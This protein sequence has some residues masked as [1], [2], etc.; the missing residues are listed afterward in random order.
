MT[1]IK[2]QRSTQGL[3]N[4][5]SVV[6]LQRQKSNKISF[7]SLFG[8]PPAEPLENPLTTLEYP[9]DLEGDVL[10][11]AQAIREA[12]QAKYRGEL[13][14]FRVQ[15][16]T[17]YWFLVCFQTQEQ[18]EQFLSQAGWP[19]DGIGGQRYLNGLALARALGL[20]I[21]PV[22][23][24]RQEAKPVTKILRDEVQQ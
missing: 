7:D 23:L 18:K 2:L 5:A 12:F 24:R 4:G 1:Q 22:K 11:E 21:Q 9:G 20:D 15:D 13:D 3:S 16:S 6:K 8:E 10:A 14:N 19:T 17:N